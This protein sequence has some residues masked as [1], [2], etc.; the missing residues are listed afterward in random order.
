MP[1]THDSLGVGNIGP[2]SEVRHQWMPPRRRQ[3]QKP[4]TAQP[5]H[6]SVSAADALAAAHSIA[7]ELAQLPYSPPSPP[8]ATSTQTGDHRDAHQLQ[9]GEA[10]LS[11]SKAR[12]LCQFPI[13]RPPNMS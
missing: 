6:A 11:Y 3:A 7:A 13:L 4:A 2:H 5:E 1:V 12:T 10:K 8:A 9:E